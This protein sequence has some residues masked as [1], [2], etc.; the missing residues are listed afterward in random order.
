MQRRGLTWLGGFGVGGI[1]GR[2]VCRA[3]KAVLPKLRVSE[4]GTGKDGV[5]STR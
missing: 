2:E 4:G 3:L 5:D 1:R